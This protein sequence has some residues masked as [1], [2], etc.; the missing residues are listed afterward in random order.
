MIV[1]LLVRHVS[2]QCVKYTSIHT[3]SHLLVD[4]RRNNVKYAHN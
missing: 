4:S 3:L 1:T 2:D